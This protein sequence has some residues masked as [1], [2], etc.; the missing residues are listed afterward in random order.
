MG[1]RNSVIPQE[2]RHAR[3]GHGRAPRSSQ[4][5]ARRF[6]GADGALRLIP[7]RSQMSVD[8]GTR[9]LR[10]GM[11]RPGDEGVVVMIT[12]DGFLTCSEEGWKAFL[13]R[14]VQEALGAASELGADGGDAVIGVIGEL[15]E[16]R[17][18][19]CIEMEV[20]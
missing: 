6:L 8:D 4:L 15:M 14:A 7:E 12:R 1:A 17:G 13:D 11:L 10:V 18:E 16:R 19:R 20:S 9:G 3:W 5:G 2:M